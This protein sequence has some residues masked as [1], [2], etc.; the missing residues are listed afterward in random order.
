MS[1]DKRRFPVLYNAE[2]GTLPIQWLHR[3]KEASGAA[4]STREHFRKLAPS[5]CLFQTNI[6]SYFLSLPSVLRHRKA[7]DGTLRTW[8]IHQLERCESFRLSNLLLGE[9][10]SREKP[11]AKG[12]HRS[13]TSDST[14]PGIQHPTAGE[15]NIQ[16]KVSE[17]PAWL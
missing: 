14:H 16:P 15:G 11:C 9:Y 2:D 3:I 6:G 5:P 10:L 7:A 8:E 13:K 12:N 1:L 4:P 17:S